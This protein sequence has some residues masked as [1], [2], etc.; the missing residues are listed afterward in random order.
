MSEPDSRQLDADRLHEN[1]ERLYRAAYALCRSHADAE[2]LV[3]D[4]YARVLR[5]P[6]FLR[7]DGD[8]PYL[9]RVLRNVWITQGRTQARRATLGDPE[10]LDLVADP[11]GEPQITA[12]EARAVYDAVADLP[13]HLRETIVAVDVAGLTYREAARALDTREGTIMSRLYRA[14]KGVASRLEIEVDRDA[15]TLSYA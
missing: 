5:R 14:R 8:L 6:R 1:F 10:E 3:Q 7:R 9:L 13:Q 11:R 15:A 4:T 12:L 2:D